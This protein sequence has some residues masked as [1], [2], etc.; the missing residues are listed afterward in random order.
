VVTSFV[1]NDG[2]IKRLGR[3]EIQVEGA[4]YGVTADTFFQPN[5]SL[6][7]SIIR[8]L[9]DQVG[10]ANRVLELYAG[11]GFFSI[12]LARIATE[13]IGI[14]S[15]RA[16]VRQARENATNNKA[17]HLRFF[18]GDV[19][20]LMRGSDLKPDVVVLDPP[21]AGASVETTEQIAALQSQK[22]VYV[23]CNPTTFAREAAVLTKRGYRLSRI[24]LIDQFPNTYHIET[25]ATL[26]LNLPGNA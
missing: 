7:S 21:R 3:A 15:N 17:P 26:E 6:L 22:I 23:S 13:V 10:T 19:N 12:P 4:H 1:L 24:T 20:T 16:A 2:T 14:E 5:R 8:E 25:V 18:E 9:V 11:A